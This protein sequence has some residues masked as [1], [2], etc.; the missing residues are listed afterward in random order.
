MRGLR[1]AFT[2]LL[3]VASLLSAGILLYGTWLTGDLPNTFNHWLVAA[4]GLA[5]VFTLITNPVTSGALG[6]KGKPART[7]LAQALLVGLG[8]GSLYLALQKHDEGAEARA[9]ARAAAQAPSDLAKAMAACKGAYRADVGSI[10]ASR[11]VTSCQGWRIRIRSY[12]DVLAPVDVVLFDTWANSVDFKHRGDGDVAVFDRVAADLQ[13]CEDDDLRACERIA[14]LYDDGR[15]TG[16]NAERR[17][18]MR[19]H[20]CDQGGPCWDDDAP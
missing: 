20:I 3:S 11:A 19:A 12:R 13:A 15:D 10:A 16:E 4:A 5:L 17:D 1:L 7:I 9:A 6:F 18:A 14:R 2:F 8:V